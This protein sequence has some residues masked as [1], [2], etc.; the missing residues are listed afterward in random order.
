VPDRPAADDVAALRRRA[1]GLATLVEVSG[2]LAATLDLRRVLQAT[3]D[4]ICRLAGLDTAAVYL[5]EGEHLRLG[6][7]TPPLP[8]DFP[9][10]L[11]RAPLGDHPHL[12]RAIASG[13]PLLVAD[14]RAAPLTAAER[15]AV[16][17]RGLR[18]ILYMPLVAGV[19]PVGALIVAS[20]TAPRPL[21]PEEVD[22][23]R[24]L[25]NLAAL[26]CE[27]ARLFESGQASLAALARQAEETRRAHAER[28]ELERQLLHAQKLESLGL[29]A[30]GV[31]HDFNNLLQATLGNLSLALEALP[32][33]GEGAAAVE[34]AA[35]AARRASDLTRQLLAYSGKGRFVVRPLDLSALV[36]E[37]AHLLRASVPRSCAIDLRLGAGLPPVEADAGQLQQVILNLITNAAESLG[38]REGA[39]TVTTALRPGGPAAVQGSRAGPVEPAAA[40]VALEVTDT[41][42]GMDAE[43]LAR[44]FEPFF[45]TKGPGG[46]GLGLALSREF[47]ERWGGRIEVAN[48]PAGGARVTVSLRRGAGPAA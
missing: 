48:R 31:A 33:G 11:R 6:A 23:C 9:E 18:T 42:T 8:P 35:L 46:T 1:A 16:E 27:N 14:A 17:Q 36:R 40:Y 7:T 25:A 4:G 39:I 19:T 29:L 24:A 2:A 10:A 21:P 13:S 22:L 12:G 28:L 34:Q 37:H 15:V 32:P 26:A 44:L 20:G 30:G 3:T 41:G 45:S 5:L 43:A 47:V 38:G